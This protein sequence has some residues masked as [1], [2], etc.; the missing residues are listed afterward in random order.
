[1]E[2]GI[3]ASLPPPLCTHPSPYMNDAL[4]SNLAVITKLHLSSFRYAKFTRVIVIQLR[5]LSKRDLID[6]CPHHPKL[7]ATCVKETPI[8]LF[9]WLPIICNRGEKEVGGEMRAVKKKEKAT[10]KLDG[11]QVRRALF[12]FIHTYH[13]RQ[14]G[15]LGKS[16][17]QLAIPP[18]YEGEK[19]AVP[20]TVPACRVILE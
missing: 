3:T 13:T 1:M 12:I 4:V 7:P 8:S 14:T 16:G 11:W 19:E 10:A 15:N 2:S 17:R 20:S 5:A 18:L 9:F 6:R